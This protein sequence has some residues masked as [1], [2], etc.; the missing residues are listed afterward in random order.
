MNEV[1]YNEGYE[2]YWD[3]HDHS[4]CPYPYDSPEGEESTNGF[5]DAWEYHE[6]DD[7]ELLED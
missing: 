4:Q 2:A 7:D 1:F 3:G 5:E 6:L